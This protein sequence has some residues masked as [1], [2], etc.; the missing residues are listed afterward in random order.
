MKLDKAVEWGKECGCDTVEECMDYLRLHYNV[1]PTDEWAE[2]EKEYTE[3]KKK[4]TKTCDSTTEDDYK[5]KA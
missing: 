1:M 4:F 2:L 5:R 3:Y